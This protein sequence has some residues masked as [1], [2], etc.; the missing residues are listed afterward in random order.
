MDLRYKAALAA[1][2]LVLTAACGSG[3]TGS[4]GDLSIGLAVSTLN[5]PYFVELKQ[6]AEEAAAELGVKLTVVDAQNDST[7]QV[8]QVQTF[9]T[10]GLKAIIINPVDSKQATPAAKAAENAGVPLIAVD[11][12]VD[13]GKVVS[14]VA[15]DNVQGGSLAAVELG[16]A[17]SGEVVHLQGIPGASASRDR[18]RGF[19]QGLNTG[20]I[21]VVASQPADFDRAKGLD[22]MTNLLQA[23]AGI[24]GVFADND[25]MALGAIKALGDK[26]G[27]QV[28]VVGFDGTPDGLKA[29]E[30]GTMAATIAQQ[31]KVL[32]RKAVEQAVKAA[33]GEAVQQVV[34]VEVKV[35]TKK[36]LAEFK[37]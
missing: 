19:E 23:N 30:D 15:S 4:G 18:G 10:Q 6:G 5:N 28:Q 11:R 21:K 26:A 20:G 35:V 3:A 8:N 33:K 24:K 7:N 9:T 31:P 22:V 37:K 12:S 1:S 17:T 32:G 14:E 36:N 27:T 13:D 25:E 2:A 29:V 16:R 34:D